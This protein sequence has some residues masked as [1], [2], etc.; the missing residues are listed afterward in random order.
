MT[1]KHRDLTISIVSYNTSIY[2]ARC[3]ESIYAN[4]KSSAVEVIVVDNA[5]RDGSVDIVRQRFSQVSLIAN[6]SN[7]Y[8][9]AAHNQALAI[10][11]GRYFLIL[12]S[13]TEVPAGT[14]ARLVE[15]LDDNPAVGAVGCREV[16][17]QGVTHPT[18]STFS[19]P[20]LEM[21][22]RT[23]LATVYRLRG[24]DLRYRM[25]D[26]DRSSSRDLDVITDCFIMV[27]CELLV[28]LGGYDER[29]LLY[30]TENDLCL[31]IWQSGYRVHFLSDCHYIH[32]GQRSTVQIGTDGYNRIYEQDMINYYRKHFGE[33]RTKLMQAG[34]LLAQN[35]V[36]PILSLYRRLRFG[37]KNSFAQWQ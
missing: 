29:F 8:L 20:W 9:S 35:G 37:P 4:T 5:S 12:N 17:P 2:L 10:A 28:Q 24:P 31:R 23:A 19:S 25:T 1:T 3:L 21:L 15:F 11:Q 36:A 32:H 27:R 26:W 33:I 16:N 18:G 22:E 14:L 13:D 6:K 7:R 34:F 30:Y